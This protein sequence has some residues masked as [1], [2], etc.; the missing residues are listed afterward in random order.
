MSVCPDAPQKPTIRVFRKEGTGRSKPPFSRGV[1]EVEASL[2]F[3]AELGFRTQMAERLRP[4]VGTAEVGNPPLAHQLTNWP[5]P[6]AE[7]GRAHV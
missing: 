4:G 2:P 7:I 5:P 3:G 6:L 1:V